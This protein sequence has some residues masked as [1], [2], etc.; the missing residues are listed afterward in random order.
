MTWKHVQGI[1][2]RRLASGEVCSV[3]ELERAARVPP[4]PP[5]PVPRAQQAITRPAGAFEPVSPPRGDR[6]LLGA[7]ERV[8]SRLT[9]FERKAF[10]GMLVRLR[11][12]R[13]ALTYA[14]RAWAQEVAVKVGIPGV[15]APPEDWREVAAEIRRACTGEA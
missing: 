15:E 14:Q 4:P 7:L 8:S 5:V 12:G 3:Y 13:Q 10:R 11:A 6:E 2:L 1:P 9:D